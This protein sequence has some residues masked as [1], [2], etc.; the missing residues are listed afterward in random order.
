MADVRKA[1]LLGGALIGAVATGVSAQSVPTQE[2]IAD[3]VNSMMGNA[4]NS[5]ESGNGGGGTTYSGE[6]T[7]SGS[8]DVGAANGLASA[9]ASG[10]NH[11]VSFVS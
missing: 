4:G 11:N 9:D 10:G 2:S 7:G 8:S 6:V 5:A 1:G 3:L